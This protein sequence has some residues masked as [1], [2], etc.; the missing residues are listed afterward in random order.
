MSLSEEQKAVVNAKGQ[1]MVV[2][3]PGSGKTHTIIHRCEKILNDHPHKSIAMVTFTRAAATEMTERLAK[4]GVKKAVRA[5]TFHAFALQQMKEAKT[6]RRLATPGEQVG[7]QF[8][9]MNR[10]NTPGSDEYEVAKE[11]IDHYNTMLTPKDDGGEYWEL[12]RIYKEILSDK[13]VAD[14]GD[15]A[16]DCVHAMRSGEIKPLAVDYLFIDEYQDCDEIQYA[17]IMEHIKTGIEVTIVGDDD[18]SIYGWRGGMGYSG[19]V[20]FQRDT[21]ADAYALTTC[22]RCSPEILE[23]ASDLIERNEDRVQKTMRSQ[24]EEK[25]SVHLY[26]YASRSSEA[27]SVAEIIAGD[28]GSQWGLLARTNGILD[29]L[30]LALNSFNVNCNRLGGKSIWERPGSTLYLGVLS[31]V[32]QGRIIGIANILAWIGVSDKEIKRFTRHVNEQ[33]GLS[34]V[35]VETA[36]SYSP[37]VQRLIKTGKNWRSMF[38]E[39][40]DAELCTSIYDWLKEEKDGKG[41][42]LGL[43]GVVADLLPGMYGKISLDMKLDR[44]RDFIRS[45]KTKDAAS[46]TLATMHSSKGLEFQKVWILSVNEKIIPS[47]NSDCLEEERRLFFVAMTR[48]EEVLVV[49]WELDKRSKFIL[50]AFTR[51]LE[52]RDIAV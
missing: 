28:P 52:K 16:R 10:V 19:F 22:Y 26:Q 35:N 3:I 9:A 27:N 48:A 23:L 33:G 14:F 1:V 25:G 2:A 5:Q 38:R 8:Q 51:I 11:A 40:R 31:A 44:L 15:L 13:G 24:K 4:R 32:C 46:V 17:W 30:Q 29:K 18:Q 47:E 21:K 42:D 49:S 12:F 50:E 37:P 43:M 39:D 20:D 34:F 7:Y 6:K 45:S 36:S 41:K